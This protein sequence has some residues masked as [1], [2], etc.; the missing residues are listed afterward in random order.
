M[1]LIDRASA[2][3]RF[4]RLIAPATGLLV[5]TAALGGVTASAAH[6]GASTATLFASGLNNPRGL[7]FGPDGQLYVAEGG[8]GGLRTTVGQ[9]DQVANIGP[10]TGDFNASISRIN[11]QGAV[12]RIVTGLPSDQT[13]PETGA[14]VSGVA[15]VAFIGKNLYGITAGAGCSHGLAGT[16]NNV[17]RVNKD[18]S[19]KSLADLSAFIMANPTAHMNTGPTGDYEP[20][21]TW[22]GMIAA[23]GALYAVEPNHGEVDRITA[24]GHISR[25]IDVSAAAY[26]LG[27]GKPQGH[28]VPTAIAFHDHSFYIANLDVFDPGFQDQSRVFKI[29]RNGG[30][31]TVAGGLNA[32]LGIGFDG[33]GRL[34]ALESFTTAFF[35]VPASGMVV[36]LN[37]SGGWDT[38][39][40]GLMF[41][42][43]MT[44]GPNGKL[45]VSNCGYL[46]G[47]GE[48]QIV[49][50]NI[51]D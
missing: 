47:P 49:S 41:P 17:F 6:G 50:V 31:Q 21:G 12:T 28:I 5:A 14:L 45:Y 7:T 8:T 24:G 39:A 27:L 18:G 20:D 44:F 4:V 34:Y 33:K 36:R 42:T 9:C 1:T 51:G 29:T 16:V 11:S 26:P 19:T 13:S 22:Y 37:S 38:I 46:C 35:P 3:S 32:V 43:G 25:V 48:G 40:S 2:R 10:Y 15:N 23:K 30:L